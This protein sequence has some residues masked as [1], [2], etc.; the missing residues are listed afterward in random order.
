MADL[1]IKT[2]M[3]SSAASQYNGA[4]SRYEK[5]LDEL[6]S[7]FNLVGANWTD[8]VGATWGSTSAKVIANLSGIS[9]NL[10]NNSNFLSSVADTATQH[11]MQAQ[12][13]V[14]SIM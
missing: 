6:S 1:V 10:R 8:E 12:S 5:L 3:L 11:Q 14:N 2:G 7:I 13:A 9:T 4:A